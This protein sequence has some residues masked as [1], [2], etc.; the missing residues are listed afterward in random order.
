[1]ECNTSFVPLLYLL[2]VIA[3]LTTF[4]NVLIIFFFH[5]F[6]SKAHLPS[7][8]IS[9]STLLQPIFY[10]NKLKTNANNK[11]EEKEN[12]RVNPFHNKKEDEE[13]E[14]ELV[15]RHPLLYAA[16]SEG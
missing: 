5:P 14:E 6:N 2:S 15:A 1:M 13:K 8:F 3:F 10:A 9:F 16:E 4:S 7:P 12:N 11:F